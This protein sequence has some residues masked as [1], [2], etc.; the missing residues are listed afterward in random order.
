MEGNRSG[1]TSEKEKV[2][3]KGIKIV[4]DTGVGTDTR[5]IRTDTGEDITAVLHVLRIELYMTVG[6][7]VE[8]H[9]VVTMPKIESKIGEVQLM[10][11]NPV[12]G[13]YEKISQIR[14]ESGNY[15]DFD[16]LLKIDD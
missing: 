3:R 8:A 11:F 6:E 7:A 12:V 2:L 13:D 9:L 1:A 10:G 14:F 16:G 15:L 5:I 4:N